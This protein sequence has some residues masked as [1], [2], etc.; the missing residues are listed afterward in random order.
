VPGVLALTVLLLFGPK[1]MGLIWIWP[2]ANAAPRLAGLA[3]RALGLRRTR[4]RPCSPRSRWFSRSRRCWAC[5]WASSQWNTQNREAQAIPVRAIL[6]KL[7]DHLLL[8]LAFAATAFLDTTTA[9]WLLPL[10]LGLF[11]APW[12]ISLTSR[13]DLAMR[14]PHRPVQG[15]RPHDARGPRRSARA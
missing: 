14:Q 7:R 4:A 15:S 6:P 13:E 8:G 11:G 10:T 12:L 1:A 3:R 5:C 2:T 9:L